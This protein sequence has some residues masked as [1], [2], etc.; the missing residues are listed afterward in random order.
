M[1]ERGDPE[2]ELDICF[3]ALNV[4]VSE[5]RSEDQLERASTK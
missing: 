1:P 3:K 2:Y 5:I 4:L